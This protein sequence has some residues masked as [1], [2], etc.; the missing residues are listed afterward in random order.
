[1]TIDASQM[2]DRELLIRID[3]RQASM[4]KKLTSLCNKLSGKVDDDKNYQTMVKKVDN[5]WDSK[6]KMIGLM[7]GAGATG[8]TLVTVVKGMVDSVLAK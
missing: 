5:L 6:N 3:E 7:I 8:G 4:I 2:K 1:M